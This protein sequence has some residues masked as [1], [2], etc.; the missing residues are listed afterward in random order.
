MTRALVLAAALLCAGFA[1]HRLVGQTK[2]V[3]PVSN[4]TSVLFD[5]TNDTIVLGTPSALMPDLSSNE[6]TV[7]MW[8][9]AASLSAQQYI[10]AHAEPFAG[11]PDM[12]WVLGLNTDGSIFGYFGAVGKSTSSAAGVVSSGVWYHFA[13]TV[14][15]ISGTYTGNLWLDGV[16][17]GSDVAS[18]GTDTAST[19]TV[20][21]GAGYVLDSPD[22]ALPFNGKVDEVCF[23]SVGFTQ[24]EV[25]E[26]AAPGNR[27]ADCT[28]HPR[29]SA[30]I[31]NYRNGDGDTYPT[32]ADHTATNDGTCT[33]MVDQS[34]NFVSDVP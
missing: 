17:R 13:Y 32:I 26:L 14:R 20:R 31:S 11:T 24:A 4:S 9:K 18:P 22:T 8:F 5:G 23:F 30:L 25:R 16:K 10:S 21:I 19:R 3:P 33:N 1:H 29:A 12:N 27:P 15:N 28:T 34:T 6:F 2:H 7:S